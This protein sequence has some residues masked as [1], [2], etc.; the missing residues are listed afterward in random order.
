MGRR[1]TTEEFL[2][3][4]S[5]VH[6]G[7]IVVVG[8]YVGVFDKI[9]VHC[10]TCEHTWC[11]LPSNLQTGCG[12]PN[13]YKIAQQGLA[14]ARNIKAKAEYADVI[15]DRFSGK[16]L[17]HSEYISSRDKVDCECTDCGYRWSAEANS[18][19]KAVVGCRVCGDKLLK[20]SVVL[21]SISSKNRFHS[22][23]LNIHKGDIS[24]LSNYTAMRDPVS[25]LCNTCQNTWSTR[26]TTLMSGSGCPSCAVSGFNPTKPSILYYLKIVYNGD[27]LYKVGV[28]NLSVIQRFSLQDRGIFTVLKEYQYASGQEC[29]DTEQLYH[30]AFKEHQYKGPPVL[31]SKGNTEIYTIDVLCLDS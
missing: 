21:R 8:T 30:R 16:I 17:L 9:E 22:D 13:C 29:Y 1:K 31:K 23:I 6:K 28:T 5:E 24:V 15:A 10:N 7:K 18:L 12:C 19:K 20:A 11:A 26:A 2:T 27:I 3:R 14:T 25:C 4:V